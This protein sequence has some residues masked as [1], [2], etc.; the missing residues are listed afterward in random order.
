MDKMNQEKL[1]SADW[2]SLKSLRTIFLSETAGGQKDYWSSSHLLELY[3]ETFAQRIGWKWDAVLKDFSAKV[4]F[5]KKESYTVLDYGSGTGIAT[6][7]IVEHL[8]ADNISDVW[9]WDKSRQAMEFSAQNLEKRFPKIPLTKLSEVQVPGG[10]W[11]LILSHIVNELS[12][13]ELIEVLSLA[14]KA[15]YV[16]WVEPG[17]HSTS[18][19]LIEI[20]K[21]VLEKMVVLAPCQ[22]Q[23]ACGMLSAKNEPHWCHHF[24]SP[25][26]EV[27]QHSFWGLFSRNLNIDL[28]SLP[29]SYLILGKKDTQALATSSEAR[30]IGRPRLYKGNGKFLLCEESGVDDVLLLE[31]NHRSLFKDYKKDIFSKSIVK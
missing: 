16:F 22:H 18:R 10:N 28:R 13:K 26:Q 7:K 17:T 11:I 19:R 2:E 24:A 25:P 30:I 27:F 31:K 12:K 1:N 8:G 15:D 20:R 14:E 29:V 9:L 23:K 6:E 21:K 3:H 4:I 5:N